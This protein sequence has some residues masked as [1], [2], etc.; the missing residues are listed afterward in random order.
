MKNPSEQSRI[1]QSRDWGDVECPA[2]KN[3]EPE[4]G[5]SRNK[6][7]VKE[8]QAMAPPQAR[9]WRLGAQQG[10]TH[11]TNK[12]TR[13]ETTSLGSLPWFLENYRKLTLPV[14][15]VQ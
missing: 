4:G 9:I 6:P 14:H 1:S 12:R 2:E 8:G 15:A 11:T 13:S 3:C 5:F 7:G 10:H